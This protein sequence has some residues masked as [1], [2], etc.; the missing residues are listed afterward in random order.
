MDA[1]RQRIVLGGPDL[2]SPSQPRRYRAVLLFQ[3]ALLTALFFSCFTFS[4]AENLRLNQTPSPKPN[5]NIS[6]RFDGNGRFPDIHPPLEWGKGKNILWQ[7]PLEVGG[8]SSPIVVNNKIFV[9]EEMGHLVCLDLAEGKQLWRKDLFSPTSKDIPAELSKKLLRGCGGD[10]KQS[11]PTPTSNGEWVFYVNAMG[12]CA[13]YDLEGNQQWIRIIETAQ[14]EEHFSASPVFDGDRILLTWG[15]L[16][17]LDAKTGKTLWKTDRVTPTHGTPLLTSIG[18]EKVVITP[19]GDIVRFE[20]GEILCT[21]LFKSTYTTPVVEGNVLYVIDSDALAFELP[22]KATKGMQLNP[23]WKTKLQGTF[24]ASP[25]YRDGLFYTVE[26]LKCRLHILEAKTGKL[27]T[28]TPIVDEASREER[29][30]TG[31]RIEGLKPA[32]YAYASP[33]AGQKQLF[34]FDDAGNA[35]VLEPGP[36]GKVV[37]I[38]RLE[39]AFSGSP[40]FVKDKIL[41]RGSRS[42]YCVGEKP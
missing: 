24:M 6:W 20:T 36:N 15:G 16:L 22:N 42:I 35:T 34:F 39:D 28:F 5:R 10:S 40:F 27:L 12:L 18:G 2:I 33:V 41:L 13:C 4:R 21:D 32:H 14:D 23:L 37:R 31:K 3:T 26:N 19:S 9:T 11:T 8:Y 1:R 29:M 38:N 7:T 17:L 30:E 25:I